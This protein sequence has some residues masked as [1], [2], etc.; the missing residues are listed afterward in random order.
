MS[1]T[2]VTFER[3]EP[4]E[5]EELFVALG[6]GRLPLDV[7]ASSIRAYTATVCA[8]TPAGRLVGYASV[9][10]DRC[11]TTMFGEFVV[12]PEF[13]RKGIGKAMMRAVEDRFPAVPIYVKALGASLGFYTAVGFRVSSTQVTS[14]FKRPARS[15]VE[16]LPASDPRASRTD[17]TA[18]RPRSE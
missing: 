14:M 8:R 18:E 4:A 12:H 13:Q 3:P 16:T 7:L 15:V 5:L 9:F 10:S 17:T 2:T 11:L 6:W 1:T